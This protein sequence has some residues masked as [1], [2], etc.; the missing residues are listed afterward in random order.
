MPS[1]NGSIAPNRHEVL[2]AYVF[3]SIE[4]VREISTHRFNS[5]V[6]E[7]HAIYRTYVL[8]S[9]GSHKYENGD[10]CL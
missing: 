6:V 10:L 2:D 8:I 1:L 9:V 5:R 3:E 4:Q 7:P